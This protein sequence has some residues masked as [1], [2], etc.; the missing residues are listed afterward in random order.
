[1]L[2]NTFKI[3]MQLIVLCIL[4]TSITN[5]NNNMNN[6][7]NANTNMN[8]NMNS[9]GRKKRRAHSKH[10]DLRKMKDFGNSTV[11]TELNLKNIGKT[12]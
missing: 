5:T 9:N 12:D 4:A 8:T 6:N 10:I 1:M 3:T 11:A 7:N 2:S